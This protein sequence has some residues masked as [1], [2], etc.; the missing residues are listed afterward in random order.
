MAFCEAQPI[1][2]YIVKL[3]KNEEICN[4]MYIGLY[5]YI[6]QGIPKNRT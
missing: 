5:S 6:S 2:I 3:Y 1:I 4:T